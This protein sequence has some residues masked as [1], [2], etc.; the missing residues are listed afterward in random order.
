MLDNPSV[1][2]PMWTV[3]AEGGPQHTKT[4]LKAYIQRLRN[5]NREEGAD[6]LEK[7][8]ERI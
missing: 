2:D 4:D 3:M 7:R 6:I 5:T 8:L 1:T